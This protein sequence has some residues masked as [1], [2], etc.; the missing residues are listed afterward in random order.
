MGFINLD[1]FKEIF[2]P[3]KDLISDPPPSETQN[4]MGST[5]E[6]AREN[7]PEPEP[8][9]D[10]E[11]DIYTGMKVEVLTL[12]NHLLF[13]GQVRVLSGDRLRIRTEDPTDRLPRI[14][15][16]TKVKV[17]GFQ[18]NF[19]TF[20]LYGIVTQNTSEFWNIEQLEYLQNQE[21]RNFFR[22]KI[23][24]DGKILSGT[25][26]KDSSGIA[27]K[28]LDISAGG[29]CVLTKEVYEK[30]D[31]FVL[32]SRFFPEEE[33]FIFTCQIQRISEREHKD[34]EYGCEFLNLS[35]KEQE[36]LLRVIFKIQ[37]ETL[38]HQREVLK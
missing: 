30:G 1:F 19:Q 24:M 4:L 18:R 13:V 11:P 15:Y 37:R 34:M 9:P 16:G 31:R 12:E 22:Q 2:R 6:T 29:T 21:S 7:M 36:R 25:G 17:R 14:L 28:I 35:E 33:P 38:Q 10:P 20:A 32:E 23:E 8:E 27:C 26:G 3:H 5:L